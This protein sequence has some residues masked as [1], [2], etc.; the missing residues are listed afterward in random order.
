[1]KPKAKP[2][3]RGRSHE[4]AAYA[5]LALLIFDLRAQWNSGGRTWIPSLVYHLSLLVL[6]SVSAIYH[7]P[8]WSPEKRQ[9]W[10]KVDHCSIYALIAGTLFP[11]AYLVLPPEMR[12]R[13]LWTSAAIFIL[14]CLKSLIWVKA[15]KPVS[16]A[17]YVFFGLVGL[18]FIPEVAKAVDAETSLGIFWGGLT[19]VFGAVI[20]ALKKPDPFP[21]TFGYHEVFHALVVVA[22][23]IQ[24]FYLYRILTT[25]AARMVQ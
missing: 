5:C 4:W 1:M 3:F 11:I 7:R 21:E 17:L 22:A 12:M 24:Y 20:Y 13:G 19:Y 25:Y 15:P 14:G 2:S 23:G 8:N 10:R 6:F 18:P 9:L 16:A